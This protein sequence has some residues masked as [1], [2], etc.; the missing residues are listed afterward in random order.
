MIAASAGNDRGAG[1]L[2]HRQ[3]AVGRHDG[4]FQ[5]FQRHKTVILR[6][7]GV[8]EDGRQLRQMAAAKKV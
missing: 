1:I 7:F 4:V 6:G 3:Q 8:I 5:H 2:T